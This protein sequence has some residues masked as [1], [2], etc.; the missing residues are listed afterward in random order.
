MFENCDRSFYDKGNLKYH[1][2]SVH[3]VESKELPYSCEHIGCN[4]K[5]K[6]RKQKLIHHDKMDPECKEERNLLVG[7][8]KSF[9]QTVNSMVNILEISKESLEKDEDYK[10]LKKAYQETHS[11]LL[12]PEFF[13]CIVGE[14]FE[15]EIPYQH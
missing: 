10:M 6:T 14:N 8:V 5:F 7:L 11:N 9:K 1:E 4:I 3:V 13:N 15:D 2:K 12:E